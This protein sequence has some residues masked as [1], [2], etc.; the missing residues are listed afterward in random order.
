MKKRAL[1]I[2]FF[3]LTAASGASAQPYWNHANGPF[4]T[5][6]VLSFLGADSSGNIY[7]EPNQGAG[8]F[9]SSDKGRSWQTAAQGILPANAHV[10]SFKT[11]P[12]GKII[13][14]AGTHPSVVQSTDAGSNWTFISTPATISSIKEPIASGPNWLLIATPKGLYSSIDDGVNWKPAT[15]LPDTGAI[16]A[17]VSDSKGNIVAGSAKRTVYR[18]LD[19]GMTWTKIDSNKAFS[20]SLGTYF[21]FDPQD[22]F[23]ITISSTIYRTFDLGGHWDTL[24]GPAAGATLLAS[25]GKSIYGISL[26]GLYESTDSARTWK[27]SQLPGGTPTSVT[28][29]GRG[30]LFATS[31]TGM[32]STVD[33]GAH[34]SDID[35]GGSYALITS[36]T[37][38][39]RGNFYLTSSDRGVFQSSDGMNW[40]N[41]FYDPNGQAPDRIAPTKDGQLA[42]L[43][44][45]YKEILTSV[46]GTS[47]NPI[48]GLPADTLRPQ[49]LAVGTDNTLY[50]GTSGGIFSTLDQ[51][52]TWTYDPDYG[53]RSV[54]L[55][56]VD[57]SGALYTLRNDSTLI[58]RSPTAATWVPLTLP[59]GHGRINAMTVDKHSVL[60][61]AC[62]RAVLTSANAGSSWSLLPL[63]AFAKPS[64]I[65]VDDGGDVV[66]ANDTSI[67]SLLDHSGVSSSI[68]TSF[69][70]RFVAIEASGDRIV[71]ATVSTG[72]FVHQARASVA[73][74][75]LPTSTIA[76]FPNPSATEI[77]ISSVSN[78]PEELEIV[79]ITGRSVMHLKNIRGAQSAF[80]VSSLPSGTYS[81]WQT[82]AHLP[83]ATFVVA[84]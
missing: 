27:S 3:L 4:G 79:D 81:V 63:G 82:G 56:N 18:S 23:Y 16:L 1:A 60:Y 74:Q 2:F 10:T 64:H 57:S 31:S 50:T 42:G 65:A 20:N 78:L 84:H 51:G 41:T 44:F 83:I 22:I 46:N 59:S 28:T 61:L 69:H 17:M 80:S 40:S 13:A 32:Y 24:R 72:V 14:L 70:A 67:V 49:T 12:D 26:D 54:R 34:W 68:D 77:S 11:L 71:A 7:A 38:D 62:D 55:L 52:N 29:D 33:H 36:L 43:N 21:H 75:S 39:G 9:R 58:E 25:T 37:S 15:P 30:S 6:G 19:Q 47:W 76:V 8:L 5:S 48:V 53:P 45:L 35:S 73:A 66:I